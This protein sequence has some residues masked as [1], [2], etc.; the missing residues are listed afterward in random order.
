MLGGTPSNQAAVGMIR[1]TRAAGYMYGTGTLICPNLVLTA[2]HVV[3]DGT[4]FLFGPQQ[5]PLPISPLWSW[6]ETA[7]SF[8]RSY[9]FDNQ[10][11][12]T[13]GLAAVVLKVP[14]ASA[15]MLI[16][17]APPKLGHTGTVYGY[18]QTATNGSFGI[19]SE[20]GATVDTS[21]AEGLMLSADICPG[22]SGGPFVT[23]S[24][25]EGVGYL[26]TDCTT[27]GGGGVSIATGETQ[28][29]AWLR[30]TMQQY[31][32]ETLPPASAYPMG[33]MDTCYRYW[34]FWDA[35]G[36]CECWTPDGQCSPSPPYRPCT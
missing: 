2:Y 6:S 34:G 8:P 12:T 20:S 21:G 24:G 23:S 1:T 22:D 4:E 3:K 36:R 18:G 15:T 7:V 14:L 19:R 25:I 16:S 5:N 27:T 29:L 9:D 17:T 13:D 10:G 33:C 26:G 32:R 11:T 28:N 31:C 35:A 30:Q